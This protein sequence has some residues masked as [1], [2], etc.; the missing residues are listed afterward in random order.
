MATLAC[1][2]WVRRR[3][4]PSSRVKEKTGSLLENLWKHVKAA[5]E[6]RGFT[7]DDAI[8]QARL[9]RILRN[10]DWD[11]RN[12]KPILWTP[13]RIETIMKELPCE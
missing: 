7:A 9:A 1:Q 12:K 10:E 3:P 5:Y 6:D 2:R 4:K 13:P 8:K 11:A